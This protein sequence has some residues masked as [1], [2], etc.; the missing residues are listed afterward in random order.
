M[1][2]LVLIVMEI[3]N[4]LRPVVS[5]THKKISGLFNFSSEKSSAEA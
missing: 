4:L 2:I 1:S 3:T 5:Y